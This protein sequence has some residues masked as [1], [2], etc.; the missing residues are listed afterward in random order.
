VAES[1]RILGVCG[2]G[3]AGKDCFYEH[4]LKPRGFIRWPMTLHYKVFLTARGYDWD[5][6]FYNKPPHIRKIL[7]EE[8]TDV[9]YQHGESI[10]LNTFTA[11]MRALHEIVGVHPP[12]V[13]ITD[14]RFLIEMRGIKAMG[15]KILHLEA[16]DQQSNMAP[17]LRGH[18]SETELDSPEML[19]L[20]DAY[21]YNSKQSLGQ[22]VEDG[23]KILYGWG[24]L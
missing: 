9:R 15:G 8:I 21:L 23:Q 7:Q 16:P 14:M 2:K 11:W 10:W 13:A 4:V 5:D 3:G 1:L 17:E 19:E 6:I 22:F 24:W 18:R 12:G 20:R